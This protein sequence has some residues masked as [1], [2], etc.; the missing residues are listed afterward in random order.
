M[1]TGPGNGGPAQKEGRTEQTCSQD[2]QMQ[3]PAAMSSIDLCRVCKQPLLFSDAL[4]E[5]NVYAAT[6]GGSPQGKTPGQLPER[7]GGHRDDSGQLCGRADTAV[8]GKWSIEKNPELN[9]PRYKPS[10]PPSLVASISGGP[11]SSGAK[12]KGASGN[13]STEELYTQ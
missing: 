8:R 3:S 7:L 4:E 10:R 12:G 5:I 13:S 6:V 9:H 1:C 2:N 11:Q